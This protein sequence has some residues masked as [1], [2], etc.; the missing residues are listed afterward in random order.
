MILL[1]EEKLTPSEFAK[2]IVHQC[3]ENAEGDW[4]HYFIGDID[5]EKINR[6][7]KDHRPGVRTYQPQSEIP[8]GEGR[9]IPRSNQIAIN[10]ATER[11]LT[12]VGEILAKATVDDEWAWSEEGIKTEREW[13]DLADKEFDMDW[14]ETHNQYTIKA[15]TME[16]WEYNIQ[17]VKKYRNIN[18]VTDMENEDTQQFPDEAGEIKYGDVVM[19]R[20]FE[21]MEWM[22]PFIYYG[23]LKDHTHPYCGKGAVIH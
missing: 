7:R 10:K 20:S 16:I 18:E 22:G 3:G 2:I 13:L 5:H 8:C 6:P 15:T 11:L 21:N 1:E 12:L 23:K 19:L 14:A 4:D 17:Q 9:K